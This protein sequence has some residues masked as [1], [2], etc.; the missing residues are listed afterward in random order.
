MPS[1][2][3]YMREGKKGDSNEMNDKISEKWM[4]VE[5]TDGIYQVS[6]LGRVRSLAVCGR[7]KAKR[8]NEYRILSACQTPYPHVG[9]KINGKRVTKKIHRLVAEAFLPNKDNLPE[10]NHID[11]DKR[12]NRVDNLEWCSSSQNVLHSIYV[13]HPN[14]I[15][16]MVFYNKYTRPKPI[17][18]I[19]KSG[20]VLN[21]FANGAEASKATGVC[22]RD[23]LMVANHVQFKPGH[24]RKTA[25]GYVWRFESESEVVE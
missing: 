14:Q 23:I 9:V 5:G 21:R 6:N 2:I 13:L 17:L 24:E 16:P 1:R 4:D 3:D 18:Q 20:I 8:S 11:G 12:N 7:S 10:V 15:A 22:Q 25:G 19:S